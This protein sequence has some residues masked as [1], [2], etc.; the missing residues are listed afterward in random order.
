MPLGFVALAWAG[1]AGQT[2]AKAGELNPAHVPQD[3]Q[4]LIHIDYESLSESAMWKKIRDE[5][6]VVSKMVQGYMK[7]RY[8]FDPSTDLKSIT[9]FSRDYRIYTGTVIVEADYDAKKIEQR[10]RQAIDYRTTMWED[11][12]LH[13]V[14]LSR[15]PA[16]DDGPSGDEEMTVVMVDKNTLLLASSV[17]NA[18]ENLDRI[19]GK[20][21]SL[22]DKKSE[23][24]SDDAADA[25]V[26]GAAINLGELK[27]H[28]VSMPIIAQHEQITWSLGE[29]SDG[30]I[31]EKAEF[32]AQSDDVAKK[33]K[34]VF[35]GV[36]AFETLRAQGSESLTTLM[37][38]VEVK[39]EGSAT[40]LHWSGA[41]DEV[42][43]AL[44]DVFA[45]ME[46]WK[47]MLMNHNAKNQSTN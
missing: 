8:G 46:T 43:A 40:S 38:N 30:M 45:R 44:D 6:A 4:W 20:S 32:V 39:Q 2:S 13:T 7:K 22:K 15:Q 3:A 11:H 12:T 9:M 34:T 24:V 41:S 29:Q 35:D 14:T 17:D 27:D 28:P 25:W 16:S 5:K 42:V 31:Y 37:K 33:M 23:L 19:A 1:I 26:Y 18:K 36:V 21:T 47:P 10:L